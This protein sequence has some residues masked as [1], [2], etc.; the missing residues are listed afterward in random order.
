LAYNGMVADSEG[1][2]YGATSHGGPTN[3]GTIYKF[4]P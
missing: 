3:D 1:N 2:F 4:T